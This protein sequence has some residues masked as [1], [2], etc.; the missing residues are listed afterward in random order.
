MTKAEDIVKDEDYQFGFH[1]NVEP[2]F[3]TGRGLTEEVVRQIS[4][5]KHE[6]KWML[7]YRLKA[8]HI[9]EK[10]PMPDFGPDLSGL[11]LDNMLYY[12]KMTDKKYRDW[13]DVPQDIK[14][15]F[16]RL[17]V[18][19]AERKYLA[20]S[21]AQYESEMVYHK[22]KEQF[23]KLGII[24]TDTDTALQE[25]PDL[26]KKYFGKLVPIDSNKFS[27]L[28]CAVWS[29]GTFIYVPKGVQVPTPVQAYFRLNAEN[30]GQFERT[31]I[32]VDEDAHLDYVEGCTAP[33]YS[34]DSL[35]AAVVEVNVLDNAYC[36]YTTI[37]NWSDNVYSL[38]TKRAVAG[39]H[40][41]MEWVDGNLGAKVTMKYPSVY[42]NG[43]GARGTMLSIAVAHHGIHQDSGAGMFHNAPNTSSSIV[44]KSIAKGGGS[45]DY[46]GSVKFSKKSD[47]S[48]AHVECDTIIMDNMSSSDTIPTNAIENSN[49]AMEHE[50]TVSKISED[51]LYYLESRGI[52]ERKATEMIIMGF[53]EPFTKQ[54]PMEYAVELNRLISF[55]MEGAIG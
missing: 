43:E 16:E 12:Q 13:K 38:E 6:P 52:P 40:A 30:S 7:D 48:K 18:P 28:N 22:M 2:K 23:D 20:G 1:D 3:S 41:T 45:T 21:A 19:Q 27:A 8:F 33:Q 24:F 31:L 55:Q 35:H 50:A 9:Y 11:D 29:G 42:L 49:V 32:I 51:Q 36:R 5:E 10:M 54:L 14:D 44:S 15:T 17:G 26:F 39:K 53:V 4:A 47:G 46:R 25:Y 34:S 37:Q